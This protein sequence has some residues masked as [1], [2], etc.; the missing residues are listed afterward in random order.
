MRVVSFTVAFSRMQA[1]LGTA[2]CRKTSLAKCTA[3]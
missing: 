3:T 1:R 2:F